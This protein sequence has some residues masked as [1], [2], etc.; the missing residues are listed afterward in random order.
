MPCNVRKTQDGA[1]ITCTRGRIERC[2]SPGCPNEAPYLCDFPVQRDSRNGTCDRRM[3]RLHRT[4]VSQ[5]RDYC[6][7]HARARETMEEPR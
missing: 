3:C 2:D 6:P 7:A 5:D 4:H 1:V